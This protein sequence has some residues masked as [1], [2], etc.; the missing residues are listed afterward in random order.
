M[1]NTLSTLAAALALAGC[2][3]LPPNVTPVVPASTSVA[4]ATRKLEAVAKER[5][6]IE[7]AYAASESV[8]YTKFFVNNCLDAAKERR[9]NLLAVQAAIEDEAQYYRRKADVEERDREV[10]KAVK[11]FEIEEA[12]AAA[13]PPPPPRAEAKAPAVIPK[14][15]LAA[16]S[17]KRAEKEARRAA[18]EAADAPKR[19]ANAKAYEERKR[20]AE[21]RQKKV[22]EKLAEKKA[23]AQA[24]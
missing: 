11:E 1:K 22:A 23:K 15:T 4:Q 7:A 6:A 24:E 9:R 13:A 14:A 20:K 12:R 3:L 21:E 17:A 2:T 18:E 5:A 10:A 19:A 16:R 8:C